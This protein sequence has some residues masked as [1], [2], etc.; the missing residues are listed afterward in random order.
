MLELGML[1]GRYSAKLALTVPPLPQLVKGFCGMGQQEGGS[2]GSGGAQTSIG[3]CTHTTSSHGK[4]RE[5]INGS[6]N[7]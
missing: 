3:P 5:G 6:T 2:L 1:L 4:W 7:S